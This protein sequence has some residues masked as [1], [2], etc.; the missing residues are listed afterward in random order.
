MEILYISV[1]LYQVTDEKE[2]DQVL[3]NT[4]TFYVLVLMRYYATHNFY[5]KSWPLNNLIKIRKTK[6]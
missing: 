4:R 5:S 1:I 6:K 2:G 3:G